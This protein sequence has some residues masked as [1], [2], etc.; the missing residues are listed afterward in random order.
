M[1]K[2]LFIYIIL[3]PKRDCSDRLTDGRLP[4]GRSM[5][6]NGEVH[7]FIKRVNALK[8]MERPDAELETRSV[9]G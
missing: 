3:N 2:T 7:A 8:S 6:E 1:K 4:H 9:R 5:G